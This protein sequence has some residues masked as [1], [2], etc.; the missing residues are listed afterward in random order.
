[1]KLEEV[2]EYIHEAIENEKQGKVIKPSKKE[3]IVSKLFKLAIQIGTSLFFLLCRE[4]PFTF[5]V[6]NS[7]GIT[8]L[9]A[10]LRGSSASKYIVLLPSSTLVTVKLPL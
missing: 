7:L 1:M 4:M 8:S 2:L 3:A 10:D 6:N 5:T 9:N